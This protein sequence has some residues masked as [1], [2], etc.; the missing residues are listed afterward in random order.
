VVIFRR[1]GSYYRANFLSAGL[2]MHQT[3]NSKAFNVHNKK[4]NVL[5]GGYIAIIAMLDAFRRK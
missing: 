3:P 2:L 5:E 4:F 1:F